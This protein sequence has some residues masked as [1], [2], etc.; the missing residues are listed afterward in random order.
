MPLFGEPTTGCFTSRSEIQLDGTR[1]TLQSYVQMP[2]TAIFIKSYPGDFDWLGYCLRSIHKFATG[3][4]EIIVAIPDT[5]SLDHLTAERVV[6]VQERGNGY[7]WQM[8]VKLD[9]PRFSSADAILFLDSDCIFTKPFDVSEMFTDDGRLKLLT[10]TWDE[11]GTGVTW[12]DP[13]DKALGW[14][15]QVDTMCRHP[16]AYFRSTLVALRSHIEELHGLTLEEYVLQQPKFIE[17]VTAGNFALEKDAEKY[18][19]VQS[20]DYPNPVR[21]H[22]SWGGLTPQIRKEITSILEAP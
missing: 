10:R 12:K 15:T 5:S 20:G 7:Y 1:A 22:W 17:F 6:R 14:S 2:T 21:Q 4:G 16:M 3:F 18:Q 8:L 9:A 13:A 19:V 11:A